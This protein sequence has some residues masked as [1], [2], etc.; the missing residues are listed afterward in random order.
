MGRAHDTPIQPIQN[1]G[2]RASGRPGGGPG[3]TCWGSGK[4]LEKGREG[5]KEGRKEK[6]KR[7]AEALLGIGTL[8]AHLRGVVREGGWGIGSRR[9]CWPMSS[10]PAHPSSVSCFILLLETESCGYSWRK[11]RTLVCD[12]NLICIL[13]FRRQLSHVY[14]LWL[15]GTWFS[16]I[17]II[18]IIL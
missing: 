17:L 15:L 9:G 11:P 6:E 1:I 16:F 18:I 7:N 2:T 4:D 12:S 3:E 10:L 14:R 5:K 13:Q 8:M